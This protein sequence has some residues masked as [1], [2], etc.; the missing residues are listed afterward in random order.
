[1][2]RNCAPLLALLSLLLLVSSRQASAQE[3]RPQPF[4]PAGVPSGLPLVQPNDNTSIAGTLAHGTRK[5]ELDVRRSDWRIEGPDG[6]GLRVAAIGEAGRM[7]TIPAPLLRVEAGTRLAVTVR[8]RLPAAVTVFGLHARS[9]A[10]PDSFIVAPDA[11]E[12]VEFEPGDPGTYLYWMREGPAPDPESDQADWEHEQLAGALVVD[13]PGAPADDRV[14]VINIFSEPLDASNPEGDWAEGLTMNG[15]SWP[16]SERMRL[17]VGE[18][19]RWRVVN[20]STRNHPMHLHGFYYTVLSRGTATAD[21]V[22]AQR[23]RRL[24]VTEA[25]RA[26]TTM[27]MEWT[28]TRPG[29]WLF[30]CHLSFHVTPDIRLPGAVEADRRHGHTHMAGLVTG[31]EVA[32]GPTDLVVRGEPVA[33]DLHAV[34]LP[35]DSGEARYG[36][37]VGDQAG[38]VPGPPLIFRQYQSADV[39]VHNEL[40][41]STGIHWHGL[42]LDAWADGVP[43]WS[44][45]D[46]KVS[47]MIPPGGS[48]TYRLSFQRPGTFIYHT[49]L[50]DIEQL[51]RGLYGAL[52]VL[53]EG[54]A[55]D[56][57]TDHVLV[58]GWNEPGPESIAG[59]DWNG[60]QEQPDGRAAVGET[61]R[62]RVTNIAPADNITA[63][64]T[65]DDVV[66]PVT[67]HAKDGADLPGHQQVPVEALPRLFVGETADF[68]WTPAEPGSYEVRLG[69]EP[70]PE[71]HLVQRWVVEE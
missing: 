12:T 53:P 4:F 21:T 34:E 65:R 3:L 47:P 62:F 28:P 49:H 15:L 33:L 13:E 1:M 67:L 29:K 48:F 57:R 45:S 59:V 43:G 25:M 32:P 51:T 46:G 30:H 58:F 68:T 18:N 11:V 9:A 42:E 70:D 36:F 10:P 56:P 50:D 41:V 19:V 39:T 66:V 54:E 71:G 5:I 61:H 55:Y 22:Y 31:I 37:A 16:F 27:A 14:I 6:P 20:A 7:P 44:A 8:N 24:V 17:E 40:S 26:R 52:L 23:D 64:V 35:A 63:W 60:S 38:S 69:Y 2:H